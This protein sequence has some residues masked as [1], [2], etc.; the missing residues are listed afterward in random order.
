MKFQG[1]IHI[2]SNVGTSGFSQGHDRAATSS[3]SLSN[4]EI[5]PL[6]PGRGNPTTVDGARRRVTTQYLYLRTRSHPVQSAVKCSKNIRMNTM[7]P[8]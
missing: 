7:L 1:S 3:G 8:M 5:L 2:C 6:Y 4:R